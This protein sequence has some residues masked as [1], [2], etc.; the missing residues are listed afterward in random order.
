MSVL[1]AFPYLAI[2]LC[3]LLNS[4]KLVFSPYVQPCC[5]FLPALIIA[6]NCWSGNW[7]TNIQITLTAIKMVT[8][9]MIIVPGMMAIAEDKTIA[10]LC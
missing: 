1:K 8:L 4:G 10:N 5:S 7:S 6:L 9:G 3:A 2:Y